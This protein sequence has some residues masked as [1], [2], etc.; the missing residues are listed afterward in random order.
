VLI[1]S[2][3]VVIGLCLSGPFANPK[4]SLDEKK[5]EKEIEKLAKLNSQA[6]DSYKTFDFRITSD[7]PAGK[8]NEQRMEIRWRKA[9]TMERVD[10]I[11]RYNERS[12]ISNSVSV[13]FVDHK[14]GEMQKF[15][16]QNVDGQ[17]R[18]DD[19]STLPKEL[20]FRKTP[21]EAWQSPFDP[22]YCGPM[23]I[24]EPL[25]LRFA[26]T[27]SD[28]FR[29]VMDLC[30]ASVSSKLKPDE[31][32][33]T[34]EFEHPGV[35]GKLRGEKMLITL[36]AENNYHVNRAEF[37]C[38]SQGWYRIVSATEFKNAFGVVYPTKTKIEAGELN[39]K[40]EKKPPFLTRF[41]SVEP[42]EKS[43][44]QSKVG[45]VDFKFPKNC[46]VKVLNNPVRPGGVG[47]QPKCDVLFIGENG[48]VAQQISPEEFESFLLSQLEKTNPDTTQEKD[49]D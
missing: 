42:F 41:F 9:D 23:S 10:S 33:P 3:F 15:S 4:F 19:G 38:K 36:S 26:F 12:P 7:P 25:L 34:I 17:V 49:K 1:Q 13:V 32:F 39:D 5:D 35:D 24:H 46:L 21:N 48:E 43:N 45:K 18:L 37:I 6:I 28:D 2:L 30:K 8:E 47:L 22:R 44:D 11:T 16:R 20:V 27:A 14:K 31:K 29:S 40:G